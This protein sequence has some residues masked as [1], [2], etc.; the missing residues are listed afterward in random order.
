[1]PRCGADPSVVGACA[2]DASR[3]ISGWPGRTCR[4]ISSPP[5]RSAISTAVCRMPTCTSSRTA[6]R[7]A[8]RRRAASA[9]P[10]NSRNS[11]PQERTDHAA[12]RLRGKQGRTP[13]PLHSGPV[14]VR[15][16]RLP[17]RGGRPGQARGLRYAHGRNCWAK[18]R[19]GPQ[20][21]GDPPA[22]DLRE[23]VS[24]PGTTSSGCRRAPSQISVPAC[25]PRCLSPALGK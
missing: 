17:S 24:Q 1:M 12:G 16:R 22:F 11:A 15:V 5:G 10:A 7:R 25:R 23:E 20:P 14:E 21:S 6:A 3:P 9:S 18:P 8:S 4:W 19:A 13:C 2:G